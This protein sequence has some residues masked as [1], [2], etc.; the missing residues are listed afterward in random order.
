M[1]AL[2]GREASIAACLCDTVVS[3]AG[4]LPPVSRTDAI[5]ALDHTLASGP[6]ITR[7]GLRGLILML[8]VVPLV[9]G[10]GHR[11]RRLS[12]AR[13]AAVLDR[14]SHGPLAAAVEAVTAVMAFSYFGD[15]AVMRS[16]GYDAEANVAR[17]RALRDGEGRW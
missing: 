17:G 2:S 4:G 9:L 13:R 15:A 7:F 5:T 12:G 10:E 1:N 8:E 6:A 16:L 14:L 3:P 11:L